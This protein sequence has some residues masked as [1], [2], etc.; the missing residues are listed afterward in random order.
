MSSAIVSCNYICNSCGARRS[1]NLDKRVHQNRQDL[2][3]QGLASYID[4]HSNQDVPGADH[5]VRLFIDPNYQV[6]SNDPIRIKEAVRNKKGGL[7]S[8]KIRAIKKTFKTEL[9]ACKSLK[10]VSKSHNMEII[11]ENTIEEL[12]L[13][14]SGIIDLASNYETV[15]LK[16]EYIESEMSAESVLHLIQ[17]GKILLYWIEFT[18]R[19]QYN[20]VSPILKIIDQ[21]FTRP[22]TVTDELYISILLDAH[23]TIYALNTEIDLNSV[24]S[25]SVITFPAFDEKDSFKEITGLDIDVLSS[26]SERLKSGEYIDLSVLNEEIEQ[27]NP[28]ELWNDARDSLVQLLVELIRVDAIGFSV[29]Y[30][31]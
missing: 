31:Q 24:I 8:P 30:L 29:S 25:G 23:A 1:V 10:L 13:K 26:V 17:W 21:N 14:K 15:N 11:V 3:I 28:E 6:R 19:F 12:N 7:P 22:P 4:I 16:I 2:K 27:T 9:F 5:G 20:F 18:G